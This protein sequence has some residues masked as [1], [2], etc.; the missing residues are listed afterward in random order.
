M[1][2]KNCV[3]NYIPWR[4]VWNKNSRI[5]PCR[6]DFDASNVTDSGYSLNDI[7]AKGRN[8]VN[9]LVKIFIRWTSHV[10]ALHTDVQ[11]MCNTVKLQQEDCCLQRYLWE[12]SL[13]PNNIF[14]EKIIQKMIYEVK[15]TGNQAEYALKLQKASPQSQF[16][17]LDANEVIHKNVYV[18]DC[19]SGASTKE[20]AMQ[21]A[22]KIQIVLSR[23]SFSLKVF[24]YS[25]DPPLESS[26]SNSKI[27]NIAGMKWYPQDDKL[28]LDIIDLNFNK[29]QR[30]KK[31]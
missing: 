31:L 9:K 10:A 21:L 5:T 22:D 27:I 14:Q 13:N 15:S 7:L 17:Y 29:N 6:I 1:L 24:K 30:S 23:G 20:K 11:K 8:N 18:D 2:K 19:L 25:G 4:A 12:E 3:H 28:S 16:E 26:S